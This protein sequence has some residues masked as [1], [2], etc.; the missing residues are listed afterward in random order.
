MTIIKNL[1]R[2]ASICKLFY[3]YKEEIASM[4]FGSDVFHL[5]IVLRSGYDW[6]EIYFTPGSSEFTEVQKEE[7]AGQTYQQKIRFLFPGED[8]GNSSDIDPV[9]NR[10]VVIR[11]D[12]SNGAM[13]IIGSISNPARINKSQKTDSKYSG[14]ELSGYCTDIVQALW[15]DE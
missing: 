3:V 1:N 13:K 4:S 7:D 14:C 11:L 15:L 5:N 8:D 2:I 6:K 9:I 10:P 12:Y